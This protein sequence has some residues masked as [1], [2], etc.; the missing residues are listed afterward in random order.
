MLYLDC[1]CTCL[2]LPWD[3]EVYR[4]RLWL[5]PYPTLATLSIVIALQQVLVELVNDDRVP[6]FHKREI[7]HGQKRFAK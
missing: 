3:S 5:F 7:K 2:L 4:L 6:Q 1:L